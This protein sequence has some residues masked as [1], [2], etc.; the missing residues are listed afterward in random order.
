[1]AKEL[2][3]WTS[4]EERLLLN[5]LEGRTKSRS[6]CF[7]DV[8]SQTDRSVTSVS[9]HYYSRMKSPV[10]DFVDAEPTEDS[11]QGRRW[12][13][14]EDEILSRH[15]DASVTNLKVCFMAVAEIVHRS[16]GAVAS[17]WYT[18]LSK[19]DLHFATI[20][21]THVAKNRKN[22][23]GVASNLTI[24]QRFVTLLNRLHI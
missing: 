22:G 5:A 6:A 7:L 3:K 8:A 23:V 16:P 9:Q 12:T 17:H 13:A 2:K 4:D 18:V 19:R 15:I 20:S 24:W 11:A 10:L 21:K 14:E 1:M